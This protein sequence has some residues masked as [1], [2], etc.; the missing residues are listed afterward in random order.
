[1]KLNKHIKRNF[2]SKA[3]FARSEGVKPQQITE[4][5]NKKFIVVKGI[6]YSPRRILKVKTDKMD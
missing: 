3:D 4:W 5:T 1:M 6:L 2:K